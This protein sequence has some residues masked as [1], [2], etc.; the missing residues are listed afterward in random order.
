M[1]P[2]RACI[3]AAMTSM[4]ASESFVSDVQELNPAEGVALFDAAAKRHLG[5]SGPDFLAAWDGG[6][7]A[8]EPERPE[9]ISVATLIP[10]VR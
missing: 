9:V 10:L 8:G 1:K 4:Q 5:I 7:F 2:K 6:E 3:V